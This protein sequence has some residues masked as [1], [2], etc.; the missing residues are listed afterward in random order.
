MQQAG[1]GYAIVGCGTMG[2]AHAQAARADTRSRVIACVDPQIERAE[3]LA[4]EFGGYATT[5]YQRVLADKAVDG[6]VLAVPHSLHCD[7][8]V[9]A[10][11]AGKHVL[12]EKPMANTLEDCDAMT[13]ACERAG[14]VLLVGHVLRFRRS[15]QLVKRIIDDGSL[16]RAFF[17]RYHNEHYPDLSGGRRWL[18]FYEEG[19][20]FLSGAVHHSDLMRWWLGEVAAVS[21]FCRTI[22]PEYI[23]SGREDHTLIVYEFANG[24]LGEST[25]TYA[26]HAPQSLMMT[27]ES[28][29]TFSEGMVATFYNGEVR[30]YGHERQLYA[31]QPFVATAVVDRSAV[32]A[33]S[34]SEVPHLTDCILTGKPPLISPQDARRAVELVLAARRSAQEG[35]RIEV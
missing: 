28:T 23:E 2:Y 1:V 27:P 30:V 4:R 31:G 19:G 26:S 22:R 29:V 32:E 34:S 9:R 12:V 3:R 14:V 10:A 13:T 33:G 35:R 21:G 18:S 25:Y 24:A 11:Q 17:A 20:V 5:E 7:Y 16:G 6:V 8:T 15:L